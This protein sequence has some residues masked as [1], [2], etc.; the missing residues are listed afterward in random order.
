MEPDHQ[1]EK[2]DQQKLQ[3]DH[4]QS[5]EHEAS[6]N[7]EESSAEPALS[8]CSNANESSKETFVEPMKSPEKLKVKEDNEQ[9]EEVDA[10]KLEINKEEEDKNLT[11]NTTDETENKEN[12]QEKEH[13]NVNKVED[14]NVAK[15]LLPAFP[16]SI[17]TK[18]VPGTNDVKIEIDS[19]SLLDRVIL[20]SLKN[21]VVD[22]SRLDAAKNKYMLNN[23][24]ITPSLNSN[25]NGSDSNSSSKSVEKL[26][27]EFK[28]GCSKTND[29]A[30][31]AETSAVE[32]NSDIS[33]DS[34]N[35]AEKCVNFSNKSPTRSEC[36]NVKTDHINDPCKVK[37][38]PTS[39]ATISEPSL[40][41]TC[42]L[43]QTVPPKLKVENEAL[44]FRDKKSPD[45]RR[46]EN[47][48]G[49]NTML[50]LSTPHREEKSVPPKKN[51]AL[52]VGLPDFSKQIF[53]APSVSRP[54]SLK[55]NQQQS[56]MSIIGPPKIRNPDF[57][58]LPR[59]AADLQMRHPDFSNSFSK[60]ETHVNEPADLQVTP[61]NFPE[62]V[63]KNNYI[64]D[65]Q[66]KPPTAAAANQNLPTPSSSSYKIDYRSS[67][68]ISQKLMQDSHSEQPSTSQTIYPNMKKEG[69]N[70]Y[71]QQMIV[72]EPMA[73]II[74]KNQF[75]P[76]MIEPSRV[77]SRKERDELS[78]VVAS[79][80]NVE[81]TNNRQTEPENDKKA[82]FPPLSHHISNDTL[83]KLPSSYYPSQPYNEKDFSKESQESEFSLKQKEQQLRQEGTIITVKNEPVK[84]PTR[85]MAERRSA[86]LF[87]DYKLKQPKESPDSARRAVDP[88]VIG[89]Q[90]TYSDY[91]PSFAP[92]NHQAKAEMI[93]KS[94]HS[95]PALSQTYLHEL[96]S[97]QQI[98][99]RHRSY[100]SSSPGAYQQAQSPMNA[101]S[102]SA[103]M[104]PPPNWPP[105]P[106]VQQPIIRNQPS[107]VNGP[108]RSS[109]TSPSYQYHSN[110]SQSSQVNYRYTDYP[111]GHY[112]S[113][114][115][116][117]Y[118]P[119]RSIEPSRTIDS[120]EVQGQHYQSTSN[121]TYYHQKYPDFSR[122]FDPEK[123][124]MPQENPT[125]ARGFIPV[126]H[127]QTVV[128]ANI[129]RFPPHHELE[130]RTIRD[131]LQ[132]RA[133][134]APTYYSGSRE[135]ERANFQNYP[136]RVTGPLLLNHDVS[137]RP[138]EE[139]Y[140][141]SRGL[142]P[143]KAE[144]KI[145]EPSAVH[146]HSAIQN[147]RPEQSDCSA[148]SKVKVEPTLNRNVPSTSSVIK[149]PKTIFSEVKRESPLD[150][151][152][153]TVKTKADSTGCDQ[154]IT[155]RNRPEPSGLKV[156]FTPDFS[157]L[158]KPDCRQQARQDPYDYPTSRI[159][160]HAPERSVVPP[161]V[162]SNNSR[163]N[164]LI[165]PSTP[166]HPIQHHYFHDQLKGFHSMKEIE[167]PR[168]PIQ[169]LPTSSQYSERLVPSLIARALPVWSKNDQPRRILQ[170]YIQTKRFQDLPNSLN[171]E[172]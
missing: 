64:S 96:Q 63:R 105:P 61:S 79:S 35:G 31:K 135:R 78:G 75:L 150:L 6:K 142:P 3:T 94:A 170:D 22:N 88:S 83:R 155:S 140:D 164:P 134:C 131:H 102:A 153:K 53:A 125:Y 37:G 132:H 66:L 57:T 72:D 120:R 113:A 165:P 152:V 161:K 143:L 124:Q 171:Q 21:T 10:K 85:D 73:H 98:P 127:R 51:H 69:I 107:P 12:S 24:N 109:A 126:E 13:E 169:L 86:D 54:M 99:P 40:P 77:N 80:Q 167:R 16:G 129:Q 146:L 148:I 121:S 5:K 154:D 151:S 49:M 87:R 136:P 81:P 19:N 27:E 116:Q 43:P 117:N 90:K 108:L 158:P 41:E 45:S 100:N 20:Y 28:G 112:T 123:K 59:G 122:H 68:A 36:L 26:I 46:N 8:E 91:P 38:D 48:E 34:L 141:R 114:D 144:R 172:E 160:Q 67:A 52:Y 133:E 157:N 103:L 106:L 29:E 32:P 166:P 14:G 145:E 50:D 70:A 9:K 156:E 11:E 18:S 138:N 115:H 104:N 137:S 97:K 23:G 55:N 44:D 65:L 168:A 1:H 149:P 62:I 76:H 25:S 93:S 119:F 42:P 17:V 71:N 33:S 56:S 130:I 110:P 15:T 82:L 118:P 92:Y 111:S 89:H 162:S 7:I 58:N 84:T 163:M 39:I 139:R 2:D 74:H 128:D 147:R 30:N 95:S 101:P 159:A 4:V 60:Q 47:Q